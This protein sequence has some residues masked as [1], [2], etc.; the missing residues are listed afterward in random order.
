MDIVTGKLIPDEGTIEGAK[1]A[2]AG[3]L[4]QMAG[5]E[6]SRTIPGDAVQAAPGEAGYP[7]A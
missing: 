5:Y 6:K 3:Y 2:K 4:D 1:Y 7:D